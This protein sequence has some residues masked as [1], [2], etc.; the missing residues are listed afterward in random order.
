[1]DVRPLGATG[2]AVPA[3][4]LGAMQLGG[5]G[6]SDARA[7]DLLSRAVALGVTLIDTA[8]S[9]GESEN[10]IARFLKRNR[11]KVLLST[12]VGY[13][14][15]GVPDWTPEAVL[16][17][18]DEAC[19]RLG[20]D[21]IDIVH[22][23]S[24]GRHT[25]AHGGVAEALGEKVR[26]GR[27]RLAAYS[28]ENE[29]LAYAVRSG[30]FSVVQA[31]VNL[32]DQGGLEG[33]LAGAGDRGIG[34]LAKR[35]LATAP[36]RGSGAEPVY[37]AR[38]RTLAAFIGEPADWADVA[39]RFAAFASPVSCCLVGTADPSHLEAALEAFEKG[40]LAPELQQRIRDAWRA[41]GNDWPGLI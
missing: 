12:K 21:T 5:P 32:C 7:E 25:L 37:E 1:M 17:G 35:P 4:G 9:Y 10:R 3:I 15:S 23:H 14:V 40:P 2:I 19:R 20:T 11:P 30:M 18:V 22:L 6:V 13:G 29:A 28:G 31:S 38:F 34:V 41:S 16:Q 39:L 36:W 8:R 33:P 27:V 26:E 24:C